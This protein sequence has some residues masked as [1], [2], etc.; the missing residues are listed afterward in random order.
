MWIYTGA[1]SQELSIIYTMQYVNGT[2]ASHL[3]PW[4][5]VV[6]EQGLWWKSSDYGEKAYVYCR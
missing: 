2:E 6:K 4:V 3:Y 5:T 1:E